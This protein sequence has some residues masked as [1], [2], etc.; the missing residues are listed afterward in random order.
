[1]ETGVVNRS[2]GNL[3]R[4]PVDGKPN[5]WDLL[6][7]TTEFA[8]NNVV[9]KSTGKSPFEVVHGVVPHLPIDLV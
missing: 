7:P 6:L 5:T 1:M 2:L 4:C 8:Y 9:N 3:F